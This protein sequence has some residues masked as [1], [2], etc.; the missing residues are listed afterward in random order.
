MKQTVQYDKGSKQAGCVLKAN[1]GKQSTA[2]AP[3]LCVQGCRNRVEQGTVFVV[4]ERRQVKERQTK[5]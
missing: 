3:C 5:D 2:R 1:T 4:R